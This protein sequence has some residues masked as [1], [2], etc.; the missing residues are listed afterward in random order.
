MRAQV[1]ELRAHNQMLSAN[2]EA[3][4]RVAERLIGL[5]TELMD[6][7]NAR[8]FGQPGDLPRQLHIH[9]CC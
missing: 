4:A 2:L 7:L 1:S 8:A 6:S 5:N 9:P 3:H